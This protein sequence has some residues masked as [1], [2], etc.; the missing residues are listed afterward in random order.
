MLLRAISLVSGPLA[1]KITAIAAAG[2]KAPDL[3]LGKVTR[4]DGSLSDLRARVAKSRLRVAALGPGTERLMPPGAAA[5]E[6][7][8]SAHGPC[9]C[10]TELYV[11]DAAGTIAHVQAFGSQ[12]LSQTVGVGEVRFALP[13]NDDA[14]TQAA[15]GLDDAAIAAL[16]MGNLVHEDDAGGAYHPRCGQSIF[17]GFFFGIVQRL[18]RYIDYGA[19]NAPV[20]LASQA[21][22]RLEQMGQ[23]S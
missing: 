21:R 19:R 9:L 4:F 22:V 20:W 1:G 2:T 7:M 11:A 17:H 8:L 13:A 14:E 18:E 10:D 6:R 23:A 15:F 12:A 16:R 3:A 5:P